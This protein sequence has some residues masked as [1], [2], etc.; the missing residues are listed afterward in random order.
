MKNNLKRIEIIIK[1]IIIK[2]L[3]KI[4]DKKIYILLN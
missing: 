4:I 3:D 1:V 2:W